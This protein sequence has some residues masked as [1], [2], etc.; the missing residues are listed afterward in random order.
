M[1]EIRKPLQGVGNIIRFNWHYYV[2][3]AIALIA[4]LLTSNSLTTALR[5]AATV[6]ILLIIIINTI[7]LLVSF[8][9]Y[10]L[11]S[12]YKFNWLD[13][14]GIGTKIINI[15]AGFDETSKFLKAKYASAD[16]TVF[17]FYDPTKHTEL[18]I[19]RARKA[20]PTFPN[21]LQIST[22]HLPLKDKS[23]D[24][25]FTI[26][27]AHEIRNQDER[28]AFFTEL[29]RILKPQGQVI[30]TE[31]LRDTANFI[32][33]NI[34]FFHF[35]SKRTWLQTFAKAGLKVSNEIKI[36]PF[37]STF[38]LTKNGTAS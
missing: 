27:S 3:S 35:Y 22:A 31:H 18:S 9:I 16:L 13:K 19:K 20:Y 4:L 21:T 23:A 12:L 32:A 29:H 17:D 6:A 24:N 10:D 36:T 30:V 25:V 5:A 34:G 11:S 14:V 2:L 1:E 38:I 15:N 33:Y 8:F 37:I 26:L 28:V 7:S